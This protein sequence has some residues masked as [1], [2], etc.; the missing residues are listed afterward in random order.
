MTVTAGDDAEGTDNEEDA[1]LFDS[2]FRD[3]ITS[4]QLRL[5]LNNVCIIIIYS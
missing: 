4:S 1:A 3:K 5:S 2:S